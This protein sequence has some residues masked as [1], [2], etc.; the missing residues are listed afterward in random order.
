MIL[1]LC[2]H[3]PCGEFVVDK[4]IDDYTSRFLAPLTKS[5]SRT[6]IAHSTAVRDMSPEP[7]GFSLWMHEGPEHVLLGLWTGWT[8]RLVR[9]DTK[10]LVE[11][12]IPSARAGS[13]P[14]RLPEKLTLALGAL[15]CEA[16]RIER[17]TPISREELVR[18]ARIYC[19]EVSVSASS[20]VQVRMGLARAEIRAEAP[21]R[22]N[23]VMF[24]FPL[25][26]MDE[27]GESAEL[28]VHLL[29][30]LGALGDSDWAR[31]VARSS[32]G[33]GDS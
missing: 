32:D 23:S 10:A 31:R 29:T 15:T 30:T 11:W 24:Y 5:R 17:D 16:V 25:H 14:R 28:L 3:L 2:K 21:Q 33:P 9:N 26:D 13:V 1:D 12:I 7:S 8:Y 18:A 19:D 22:H 27:R 4:R 20:L 6:L